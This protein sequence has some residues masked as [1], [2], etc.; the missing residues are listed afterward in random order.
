MNEAYTHK[1]GPK[2]LYGVPMRMR[3]LRVPDTQWLLWE[4]AASERGQSVSE[5]IRDCT[6]AAAKLIVGD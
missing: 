6:T 2:P 3:R 1:I 5:L 4:R